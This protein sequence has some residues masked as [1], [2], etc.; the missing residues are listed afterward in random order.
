[1]FINDFNVTKSRCY[2]R[3]KVGKIKCPR[4][5]GVSMN[6]I[7]VWKKKSNNFSARWFL[8]VWTFRVINAGFLSTTSLQIPNGHMTLDT[9]NRHTDLAYV[10]MST[11]WVELTGWLLNLPPGL[12]HTSPHHTHRLLH[13]YTT[14][15][16]HI[17]FHL[18]LQHGWIWR[19]C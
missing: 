5:R 17:A 4:A 10:A 15:S 8:P 16:R 1:M 18:L 11:G 12:T 13:S 9:D 7:A 6:D 14:P 2:F 3:V 19:V